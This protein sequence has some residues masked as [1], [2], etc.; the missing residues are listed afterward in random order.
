MTRRPKNLLL[1]SCSLLVLAA[2]FAVVATAAV[3]DP[4][5]GCRGKPATIVGTDGP[6][7]IVGTDKRDVIQGG[8]G[9]DTIHGGLGSDLICGGPGSDLVDGG[10]GNDFI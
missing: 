7:A 4:L 1:F 8:L 6:D 10:R 9:D 2:A 3:N 5:P